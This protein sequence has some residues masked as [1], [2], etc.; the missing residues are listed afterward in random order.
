MDI[1]FQ[2]VEVNVEEVMTYF[3]KEMRKGDKSK[4]KTKDQMNYEDDEESVSDIIKKVH[5]HTHKTRHKNKKQIVESVNEEI[6]EIVDP[7]KSLVRPTDIPREIPHQ[8][9]IKLH[10]N[11]AGTERTKQ[12]SDLGLKT[13]S[14]VIEHH[15]ASPTIEI[16]AHH[17]HGH[18]RQH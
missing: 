2:I 4:H 13:V 18:V 10:N 16:S 8:L 3:E 6:I 12:I 5:R 7:D 11:T 15:D 14:A 17:K 1:M 9:T